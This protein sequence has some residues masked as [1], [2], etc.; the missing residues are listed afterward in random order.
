MIFRLHCG[1]VDKNEGVN[2]DLEAENR[3]FCRYFQF[4]SGPR[5]LVARHPTCGDA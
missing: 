1:L 5:K 2:I 3:D 4:A